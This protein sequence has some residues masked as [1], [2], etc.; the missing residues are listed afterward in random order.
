MRR[1]NNRYEDLAEAYLKRSITTLGSIQANESG[2]KYE[3]E[4]RRMT[5]CFR[6]HKEKAL[7]FFSGFSRL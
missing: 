3:G 2:I 4:K 6:S 5:Y 7:N 1:D